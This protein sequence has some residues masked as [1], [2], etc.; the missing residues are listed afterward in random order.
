MADEGSHRKAALAACFAGMVAVACFAWSS[1]P[2]QFPYDDS[3]IALEFARNLAATGHLT[4]DGVHT[5]AGTTTLLHIMLLSVPARLGLPMEMSDAALGVLFF[6]L[7]IERTAALAMRLTQRWEAALYAAMATALTGYLVYDALNGLE[8]TMFMLLIVTCLGSFIRS[9]AG[10]K[11]Y[12]W[13]GFWLFL[14][15]LARPEGIWLA[16]SLILYLML[17]ALRRREEIPR[18]AKLA[19]FLMGGVLLTLV[20]QRL[21]QGTVTPHTALSKVYFYNQFRQPFLIRLKGYSHNLALIWNLLLLPLLPALWARKSR[22]LLV[23][24]LPW[25]II[26]QVMFVMLLPLE[27]SAYQGRYLHPFMPLFFVMAG[28]GAN[29]LWHS[30]GRFQVPRWAVAMCLALIAAV[31][32]FNLVTLHARY[33]NDKAIIRDNDIWATRWLQAHAAPG[34]RVAAYDIGALRYLGKFP[35]LD[36]CGLTDEAVMER[37]RTESGQ[38]DYLLSQ[39]PD[40]LVGDAAWLKRLYHYV[41]ADHCCAT[42]VAVA[43][44]NAL[45]AIQ[46]R[47]YHFLWDQEAKGTKQ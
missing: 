23:M 8:T 37:N 11:G 27:V 10:G 24:I 31:C 33:N 28:D 46:F 34:S 6:I 1:R 3:Y 9:C 47:I 19:A 30:S 29:N 26:T 7:L 22:P 40:Y 21:V 16:V 36:L 17:L 14:T 44:P 12:A 15:A 45:T 42:E 41:P 32:Y 2:F 4:Y 5:I 25:I 43:H 39:R 35:L 20:T 18:L 38:A 13:S